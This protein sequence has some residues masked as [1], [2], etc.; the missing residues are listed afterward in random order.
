MILATV[1]VGEFDR[2]WSV[3]TG[4]GAE[5]RRKHGSRGAQVLRNA[6]DEHEIWVLFDWSE[7]DYERFLQ[8]PA[9][10]DVMA[11]AGLQ[12][13]PRHTVVN[14]VGLTDS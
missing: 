10:R 2:F 13:P 8:D 3:F 7:D 12:G 6:A 5:Q 9:S 1:T 11:A 14:Q 4:D